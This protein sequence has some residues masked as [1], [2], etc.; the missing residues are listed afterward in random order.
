MLSRGHLIF[1]AIDLI[2]D[3]LLLDKQRDVVIVL[4]AKFFAYSRLE[5]KNLMKLTRPHQ[6][7]C[8]W[9]KGCC[10]I[11]KTPASNWQT[12]LSPKYN[13]VISLLI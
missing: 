12:T 5:V 9:G 1:W 7:Q 8:F 4:F 10:Q 3:H 2:R 6:F 13:D 11:Q